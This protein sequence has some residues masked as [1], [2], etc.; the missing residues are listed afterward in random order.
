MKANTSLTLVAL[1]AIVG[2]SGCGALGDTKD[3]PMASQPQTT[4]ATSTTDATPT[5]TAPVTRSTKARIDAAAFLNALVA[6]GCEIDEAEYKEVIRGGGIK[7]AC[8]KATDPLNTEGL[9]DL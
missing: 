8:I 1:L 7:V 9:E 5:T 4:T 2:L 6:S 3:E